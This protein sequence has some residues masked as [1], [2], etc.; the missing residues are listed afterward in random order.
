MAKY[1]VNSERLGEVGAEF[2]ADAAAA[3]GVNVE[4]LISG[5]FISTHKAPKGAKKDTDTSED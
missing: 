5:G 1:I 4:A 2:D 3:T